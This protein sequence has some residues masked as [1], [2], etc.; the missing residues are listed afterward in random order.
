MS[1]IYPAMSG[2]NCYIATTLLVDATLLRQEIPFIK[3]KQKLKEHFI[4]M[5]T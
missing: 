1:S 4:F 3:N 5:H 2:L